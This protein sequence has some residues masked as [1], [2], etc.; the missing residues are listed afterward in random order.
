MWRTRASRKLC[1][2]ILDTRRQGVLDGTF[3]FGEGLA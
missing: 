3:C 2:L 1:A